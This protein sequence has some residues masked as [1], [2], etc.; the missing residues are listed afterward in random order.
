LRQNLLNC[1][2]SQLETHAGCAGTSIVNSRK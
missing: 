1:V 2:S